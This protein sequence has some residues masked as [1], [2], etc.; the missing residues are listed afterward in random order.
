[1][2]DIV[3]VSLMLSPTSDLFSDSYP[4]RQ[5]Y[6][7]TSCAGGHDRLSPLAVLPRGQTGRLVV[8]PMTGVRIQ[9]GGHARS[10][11]EAGVM[12]LVPPSPHRTTY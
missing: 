6:V 9:G 10:V 12:Q 7:T 1:M 4:N 8:R 2:G 5:L 11:A 3:G